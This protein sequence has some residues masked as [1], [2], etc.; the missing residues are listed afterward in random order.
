MTSRLID[1]FC[2]DWKSGRFFETSMGK[3]GKK[4]TCS[5]F[6]MVN[7]NVEVL[8]SSNLKISL[9]NDNFVFLIFKQKKLK[10]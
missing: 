2:I 3:N 9:M 10:T 7:E 4:R 8:V 1:D 6:I 5:G